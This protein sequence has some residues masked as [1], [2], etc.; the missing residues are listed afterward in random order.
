VISAWRLYLIRNKQITGP[1]PATC[2]LGGTPVARRFSN[3]DCTNFC[4][5]FKEKGREAA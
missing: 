2:W 3:G 1:I 5:N 4:T